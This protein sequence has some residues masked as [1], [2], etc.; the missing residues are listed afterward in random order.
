M[1]TSRSKW[2]NPIAY[3]NTHLHPS[4]RVECMDIPY[5]HCGYLG[6]YHWGRK[7]APGLSLSVS[8]PHREGQRSSPLAK[9][10]QAKTPH[11]RWRN[12]L[13]RWALG[14]GMSNCRVNITTFNFPFAFCSLGY[15]YSE[16]VL[17][18]QGMICSQAGRPAA[19]IKAALV[20]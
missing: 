9:C 13:Q 3:Y 17:V 11:Q 7:H 6:I 4:P 8:G 2:P 12:P 19:T 10:V 1:W 20:W 15:S 16:H 18:V 14:F 5:T